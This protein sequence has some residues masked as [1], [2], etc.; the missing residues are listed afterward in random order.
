MWMRSKILS[1]V[2]MMAP[3]GA[4]S[5]GKRGATSAAPMTTVTVQFVVRSS[6]SLSHGASVCH[7][8]FGTLISPFATSPVSHQNNPVLR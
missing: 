2:L 5:L 8:L 6:T 7:C 1:E 3:P 4:I